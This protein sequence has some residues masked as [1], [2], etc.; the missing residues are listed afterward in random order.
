MTDLLIALAIATTV[1]ACGLLCKHLD[2]KD[3]RR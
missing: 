1:C 2:R 3:P